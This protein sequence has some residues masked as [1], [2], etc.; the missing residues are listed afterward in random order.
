MVNAQK[1]V[2]IS[3]FSSSTSGKMNNFVIADTT[4]LYEV[5]RSCPD[6]SYTSAK[7]ASKVQIALPSNDKQFDIYDIYETH[8][9]KPELAAKYPHIKTY[10]AQCAT[11]ESKLAYITFSPTISEITFINNAGFTSLKKDNITQEFRMAAFSKETGKN[12]ICGNNDAELNN[13]SAS[14]LATEHVQSCSFYNITAAFSCSVRFSQA[15][16]DE[17]AVGTSPSIAISLAKITSI[18]NNQIN[19]VYERE[20]AIFFDLV[21]DETDVILIDSDPFV[22]NDLSASVGINNGFMMSNINDP[23]YKMGFLLDKQTGPVLEG[24]I[25]LSSGSICSNDFEK[26]SN[27]AYYYDQSNGP[28]Q[29]SVLHEIGHFLGAKHTFNYH[30]ASTQNTEASVELYGGYSIMGYGYNLGYWPS[31][32][33]GL[34]FPGNWPNTHSSSVLHF[35]AVS[36]KQIFTK[37]AEATCLAPTPL[38]CAGLDAIA[39]TTENIIIPKGTSFMLR[40]SNTPGDNNMFYQF[41]QVDNGVINGW[42]LDIENPDIPLTPS[43]RSTNKAYRFFRGPLEADNNQHLS[44][45]GREMNFNYLKRR[46]LGGIGVTDINYKKVTVSSEAGPLKITSINYEPDAAT[47]T[48]HDFKFKDNCFITWEVNDTRTKLSNAGVLDIYLIALGELE[49]PTPWN[50]DIDSTDFLLVAKDVAN[51]GFYNGELFYNKKIHAGS[52]RLVLMTKDKTIFT[53]SNSKIEILPQLIYP[54]GG[55]ILMQG[56]ESNKAYYIP[57]E[58]V[59]TSTSTIHTTILLDIGAGYEPL[60]SQAMA[61]DSIIM[62]TDQSHVSN[63]CKIKIEFREGFSGPLLESNTLESN[64]FFR[65][66]DTIPVLDIAINN[67]TTLDDLSGVHLIPLIDGVLDTIIFKKATLD[68]KSLVPEV[69][70]SAYPEQACELGV[71][72]RYKRP[73]G[74]SI[75]TEAN[76]ATVTNMTHL[77]TNFL[78]R[79]ITHPFTLSYQVGNAFSNSN[80]V[81]FEYCNLA[82]HGPCPEYGY[83]GSASN[84]FSGMGCWR[85]EGGFPYPD[86][87]YYYCNPGIFNTTLSLNNYVEYLFANQPP[88]NTETFVRFSKVAPSREPVL[89]APNGFEKIERN[90][91]IVVCWANPFF[92]A[93][94]SNYVN[95]YLSRDNGSNYS[96]LARG[97][98]SSE[99]INRYMVTP[100]APLPPGSE[101]KIKVE[102]TKSGSRSSSAFLDLNDVSDNTFSVIE[103]V[104]ALSFSGLSESYCNTDGPV[105]LT[106]SPAGGIFSGP[107]ISGDT[108]DPANITPG[109]HTI[110]Y[111]YTHPTGFVNN[112]YQQVTVTNCSQAT[113]LNLKLFIQGYYQ[114]IGSSTPMD[115]FGAGG[116]LYLTG[117]ST[118]A[119]DADYV[120]ISMM[121]SLDGSHVDSYSSLLHTDGT[122]SLQLPVSSLG[123]T[124]YLRIMHRNSVETWSG[125]PITINAVTN[126]D[127]TDAA[128]KAYGSNQVEVEPGIWAIY[129]GDI[130]DAETGTPG[131]Q[132]GVIESSDYSQMEND[133][134]LVSGGY[135]P[136]DITGD[137]VVESADYSIME[138][139]VY[140]VISV[141]R[142]F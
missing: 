42:P 142:P 127:F 122:V 120:T 23:A 5:L 18:L 91:Y 73:K 63:T 92:E 82:L 96:L 19:P 141:A 103:D 27:G 136:A 138:N 32:S 10:F 129:S 83:Q 56:E 24:N 112:Y 57:D 38:P 126:Y 75:L 12:F 40:A 2:F 80:S 117:N 58:S 110:A 139:N 74:Y 13:R 119:F 8:I 11:D 115:N 124:Y 106:G 123:N 105:T 61:L 137:G 50:F 90:G 133:V 26:G 89:L 100:Q 3:P 121:S 86:T 71:F 130:I 55:E 44:N 95:I 28:R 101:Y 66:I 4:K 118:N 21:T 20:A 1:P 15:A 14:T 134:Y 68:K 70:L 125:S 16:A 140:L 84:C 77:N 93:D 43:Y 7:P 109:T 104:E 135:V 51:L 99:I 54:A 22:E 131:I 59:R 53:F 111:S 98:P 114:S 17:V 35:N 48:I 87:S 78:H 102:I 37:L 85:L 47:T 108:F 30:V 97:V 6:R 88:A 31:A 65:I 69:D 107:G 116:N 81:T 60:H 72:K 113:V 41:N 45:V 132:D 33:F 79:R 39:N 128:E 49:S 52:Y 36:L 29:H 34:P 67:F 76:N 62:P 9:L 25:G 94:P 64:D 46:V